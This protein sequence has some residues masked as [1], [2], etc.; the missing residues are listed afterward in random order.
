M[1]TI[2]V[3]GKPYV[4]LYGFFDTIHKTIQKLK[5]HLRWRL[6]EDLFGLCLP[7]SL[8][9]AYYLHPPDA[10]AMFLHNDLIC[11]GTC[12]VTGGCITYWGHKRKKSLLDHA[13]HRLYRSCHCPSTKNFYG[14]LDTISKT[15]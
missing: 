1:T 14:V 11:D 15:A 2:N 4:R 5:G 10:R 13:V 12:S 3:S 8:V 9:G 6:L 7:P